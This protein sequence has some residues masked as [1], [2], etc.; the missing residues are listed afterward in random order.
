MSW[1]LAGFRTSPFFC[2]N[3][4]KDCTL[5]QQFLDGCK[6]T[7]NGPDGSVV[8]I[9]RVVTLADT[10]T[11]WHV[12]HQ[13]EVKDWAQYR[14]LSLT[15]LDVRE[16]REVRPGLIP[17]NAL[18]SARKVGIE[19]GQRSAR[20][21]QS[22]KFGEELILST[23]TNL[24]L[25]FRPSRSP[26]TMSSASSPSRW[27]IVSA[28]LISSD[29]VNAIQISSLKGEHEVVAVAARGQK[30]A[31]A[32]AAKFGIKKAYEGYEKLAQDPDVEVVYIGSINTTHLDLCR[33]MINAGKHVL[34][35]KPLGMNVK[36][37]RAI[38]DCAKAKGVFF[39]EAMWA[40]CNPTYK[41]MQEELKTG[42]MGQLYQANVSFGQMIDVDRIAKKELGGGALLDI[43]IYTINF[44]QMAFGDEKPESIVASGH[45]NAD[46]VDESLGAVLKYKNGKMGC[47]N[48]HSK[49]RTDCEAKLFGTKGSL[50]LGYP[51][52]CATDMTVNDK[53]AFKLNLPESKIDFNFHNSAILAYEAQH[54]R[55]CLLE[56]V[57]ESPLVSHK[58]TLVVAE[59]MEDI[60]KQIGVSYPQ[61]D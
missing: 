55:E 32:F 4:A 36:E 57:K 44:I 11:V 54:V 18:P 38:L 7:C 16:V 20:D 43:G 51:F 10:T 48:I 25:L 59:I 50:T 13:D 56:G 28:G 40:R 37:T 60:R 24:Y 21:A 19:P 45:M 9:A 42:S 35:E 47:L 30:S 8:G 15:I 33:M 41:K 1:V 46:G 39:M 49:V 29:F 3:G 12:G 17:N 23:A 5:S 34:C 31:D 58:T 53:P 22:L 27:G 6:I 26:T 14:S 52:W 61:D 2:A